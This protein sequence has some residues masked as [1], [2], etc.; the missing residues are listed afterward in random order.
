[1][2]FRPQEDSRFGPVIGWFIRL[3]IAYSVCM[4]MVEV[5]WGGAENSRAGR[6]FW[7]WNERIVAALFTIEFFAR[8][9]KAEKSKLAYMTSGFG[10]LDLISIL[11]FWAGFFIPLHPT[12]YLRIIRSC[13]ILRLLKLVRYTPRVQLLLRV[14]IYC[15]P[16]AMAVLF[17]CFIV[18]LFGS[19]LLFEVERHVQPDKFGNLGDSMWFVLI[20]L[21]TIGF[22]DST[23]ITPAGKMICSVMIIIGLGLVAG[24]VGVIANAVGLVFN[25]ARNMPEDLKEINKL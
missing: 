16:D 5:D 9:I 6:P 20:T 25:V 13:R 12:I 19:T 2:A 22:G 23:P 3:L 11:P 24:F 4:F 8:A 15:I 10:I 14:L 1:M 21:T 17:L 7:L 18:F